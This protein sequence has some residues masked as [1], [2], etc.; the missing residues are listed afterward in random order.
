MSVSIIVL[1]IKHNGFICI[2]IVKASLDEMK[3]LA[4]SPFMN[5]TLKTIYI[6]F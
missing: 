4:D 5:S 6:R 3:K 2:E 1:G